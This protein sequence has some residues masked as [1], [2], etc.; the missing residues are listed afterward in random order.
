MSYTGSETSR[1]W[2]IEHKWFEFGKD[3]NCNAL[4]KTIIS[5]KYSSEWR[6]GDESYY[7][8]N[9]FKNGLLY[10]EYEKLTDAE[11]KVI[12]GGCLGEYKYYD[13]TQ[14]I[15]AVLDRYEKKLGE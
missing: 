11:N 13:M 15:V 3:E 9:D 1:T 10:S 2:I 8:I 12:L 7:P 5:R 6:P 4:P 14:V